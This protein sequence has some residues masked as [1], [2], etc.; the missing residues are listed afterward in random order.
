MAAHS[1]AAFN[2]EQ[3]QELLALGTTL[4]NQ[5][6]AKLEETHDLFKRVL[7]DSDTILMDEDQ[8]KQSAAAIVK[9]V[10][11][12]MA[13]SDIEGTIAGFQKGAE[14]IA[15][16]VGVTIRKNEEN[17]EQAI[18]SFNATVKKAGDEIGS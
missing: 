8:Y 4:S 15:E 13:A 7:V 1:M 18:N 2:E 5:I 14:Q 17:L 12:I 11:D 3:F 9:S 16:R 6:K 10:G